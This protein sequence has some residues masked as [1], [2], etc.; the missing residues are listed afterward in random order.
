MSG[1]A[2]NFYLAIP[3]DRYKCMTMSVNLI[4]SE[5]IEQNNLC[6]KFKKRY[7]YMEI[8]RGIYELP[9]SGILTNKLL[10]ERLVVHGCYKVE[11]AP[12]LFTTKPDQ[13]GYFGSRFF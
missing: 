1:D 8:I 6:P 2:K 5:F 11:H 13:F 9:Q 3:L 10:K 7:F 4:P 12:I